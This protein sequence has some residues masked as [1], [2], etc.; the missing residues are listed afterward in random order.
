M[1]LRARSATKQVAARGDLVY[2]YI[3]N[4]TVAKGPA[5]V[6]RGEGDD[7]VHPGTSV[8]KAKELYTHSLLYGMI[9]TAFMITINL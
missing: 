3:L 9:E 4:L 7:L 8:V 2:E 1:L 6:A 5:A